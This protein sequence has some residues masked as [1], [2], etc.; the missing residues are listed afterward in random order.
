SGVYGGFISNSV[1][2]ESSPIITHTGKFPTTYTVGNMTISG[3]RFTGWSYRGIRIGGHSS[4]GG[5]SGIVGV[6]VM[7]NEMTG[8]NA[9]ANSQT[10]NCFALW[11]D[12]T[13][14]AVISNN[15]IHDCVGVVAASM[16]HLSAIIV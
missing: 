11:I 8:S 12:C 1:S 7:N 10:D 4:A 14:G 15:W 6:T 13:T 9:S 16:D 2:T 5:P 3:L